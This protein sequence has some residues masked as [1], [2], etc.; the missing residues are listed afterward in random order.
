MTTIAGENSA[1]FEMGRAGIT[2]FGKGSNINDAATFPSRKGGP[3]VKRQLMLACLLA[4][5]LSFTAGG[6][7]AQMYQSV[8]AGFQATVAGASQNVA[9]RLESQGA[10]LLDPQGQPVCEIWWSKAIPAETTGAAAAP[11]VFY[12]GLKTGAFIGV[13]HFMTP[14]AEDFRDQKL[15]PGFYIM[16]YALFPPDSNPAGA[17]RFR[18]F[19]V[20]IPLAADAQPERS[21]TLEEMVRLGCLA[22]RTAYP[23]IVGLT[24]VNPAYEKLPAVVA[25]DQGNCALQIPAHE[26]LPGGTKLQEAEIAILVVTAPKETGGS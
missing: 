24:H 23:A 8:P 9:D 15:A 2:P 4:I 1:W 17:S 11:G 3:E 14:E 19:V 13:L 7:R 26:V 18:E 16:R 12:S 10:R 22:S 5:G 6:A 25:D 20:L 21:L